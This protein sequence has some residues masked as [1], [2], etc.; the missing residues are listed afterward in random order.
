MKKLFF[1]LSTILILFGCSNDSESTT[2]NNDDNLT[3]DDLTQYEC[4]ECIDFV[5][6][7]SN[8]QTFLNYLISQGYDLNNDLK[9]SCSEA[10]LITELDFGNNNYVTN[11]DGIEQLKNL[12]SIRGYLNFNPSS[13]DTTTKLNLYNNT[14]VT[15]IVFNEYPTGNGSF[16]Y[17]QIGTLI[18]PN[19]TTLVKLYSPYT[20]FKNVLNTSTQ[21]S[22]KILKLNG[23]QIGG[24]LDLFECN[25]L[26][27][28]DLSLTRLDSIRFSNVTNQFLD[29]LKIGL[30]NY[31]SNP[32]NIPVGNFKNI[33]LST[34]P[35]LKYLD[36][37][38]NKFQNIDISNNINLTYLNIK[39]NEILNLNLNNNDLLRFL[40]ADN[41]KISII[42]TSNLINLRSFSFKNNFLSNLDMSNN[43]NLVSVYLNNN[44]LETLNLQNGNN[45]QINKVESN[46]NTI[47]CI[48]IDAGFVP[49]PTIWLKD[50]STNYCN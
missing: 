6:F 28:I 21:S 1:T 13:Q 12:I 19:S 11:T 30:G 27:S 35:N 48:I 18:L 36:V 26:Q 33:S 9:I 43:H 32:I 40:I 10:L 5:V 38:R 23:S 50:S 24:K 34:F 20:N 3:S 25:Q 17:G 41:N 42:N 44:D 37:S 8:N 47:N 39:Y 49:N 45:I 46:Q 14:K 4:E 2:S 22:L 16:A 7:K 15:E 29:T 31:G